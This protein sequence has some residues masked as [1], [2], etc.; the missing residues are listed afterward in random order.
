M[1][2]KVFSICEVKLFFQF[3]LLSVT[4]ISCKPELET[5]DLLATTTS[6]DRYISMKEVHMRV[7]AGVPTEIFGQTFDQYMA[8]F[9]QN[10]MGQSK[11]TA[12]IAG[13]DRSGWE[14]LTQEEIMQLIINASSKY[15]D[16][17]RHPL[18]AND[19][20]RIRKDFP[21][22]KTE[23]D[24]DKN[25]QFIFD[26]YSDLIKLDIAPELA[27]RMKAKKGGKMASSLSSNPLENALI[28]WNP[29]SAQ[30]VDNARTMIESIIESPSFFGGSGNNDNHNANAFKHAAWNALGVWW[31]IEFRGNK[32]VALDKMKMFATAHETVSVCDGCPRYALGYLFDD[33]YT[34]TGTIPTSDDI[35]GD[36]TAMDLHNN[37]VGRTFMYNEVRTG[38]FGIVTYRP[39]FD[40]ILNYLKEYACT[41]NR[42]HYRNEVLNYYGNDYGALT[43][44]NYSADYRSTFLVSLPLNN[45][46]GSRNDNRVDDVPCQ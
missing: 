37:M 12:R 41:S 19:L 21:D 25:G 38:W 27:K 10:M 18:R 44:W 36:R 15:P 11:A 46:D 3:I 30:A 39:G 32:W 45:R 9:D 4:L 13:Q 34:I 1:L 28:A 14:L 43:D 35:A 8:W 31:I 40:R 6:D 17:S 24:V 16:L 5:A 29:T 7:P 20:A 26:Y 22:I 2:N 33:G 23:Q 42:K